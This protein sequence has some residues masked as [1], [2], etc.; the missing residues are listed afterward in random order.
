MMPALAP[1]LATGQCLVHKVHAVQLLHMV[2]A[3]QISG[4]AKAY[5]LTL[6]SQR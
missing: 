5:A 4:D 2:L 3:C 1:S 6:V